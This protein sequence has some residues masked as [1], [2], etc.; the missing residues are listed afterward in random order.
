[1]PA[2]CKAMGKSP[3]L[4]FREELIMSKRLTLIYNRFTLSRHIWAAQHHEILRRFLLF[5]P[6]R[7]FGSIRSICI[8]PYVL[9]D[10]NSRL[11]S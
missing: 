8:E 11:D 6:S 3:S 5:A 2:R 1:M 9:E 10:A 7:Y 4:F